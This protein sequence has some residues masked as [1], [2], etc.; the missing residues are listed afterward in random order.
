[1][2]FLGMILVVNEIASQTKYFTT[3]LN[4]QDYHY[5]MIK[6]QNINNTK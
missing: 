6:K 4:Y 3:N 5:P 1:M 2:L